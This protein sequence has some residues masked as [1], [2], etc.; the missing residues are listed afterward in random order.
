MLPPDVLDYFSAA[1][2]RTI[3]AEAGGEPAIIGMAL[4]S[5]TPRERQ[6]LALLTTASPAKDI[7]AALFISPNTVKATTQRLYRKLNVTS[8]REAADIARRAGITPQP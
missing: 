7:A 3:T 6:I 4:S 2:G 8:R 1:T 5:L